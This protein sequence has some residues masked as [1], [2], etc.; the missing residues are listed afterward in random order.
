MPFLPPNQQWCQSTE[1]NEKS[2]F[3][4]EQFDIYA[5]FYATDTV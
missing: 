4:S 2:K 1:G 3:Q 5:W